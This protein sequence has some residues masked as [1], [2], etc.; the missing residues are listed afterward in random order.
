MRAD[1]ID[2]AALIRTLQES[3]DAITSIDQTGEKKAIA[4]L[5][6]AGISASIHTVQEQPS[7]AKRSLLDAG[8]EQ[9]ATIETPEWWIGVAGAMLLAFG[10]LGTWFLA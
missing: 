3:R 7:A 2:R 1:L 9:H 6:A 4:D 5:I 8:A 10:A